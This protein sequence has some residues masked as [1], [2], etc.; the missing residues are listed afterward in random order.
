MK[1]AFAILFLLLTCSRSHSQAK[2]IDFMEIDRKAVFVKAESPAL[3]AEKLTS[4]YQTDIEKVRSIFRW[5]AEHIEYRVKFTSRKQIP[6]Q[7]N[8]SLDTGALT[9]LDE[10][11]A[12]SVF[13]N[14][15]AVCDGYARLFKA[16]CTYSGIQAV[17]ITGYA[18]T[19]EGRISQKFRSNH[20]WNA[21]MIDG[22]WRLIDVTWASGFLT[23]S[24]NEF[25]RRFDDRYFLTEPS[26]FIREHYPDDYRWTLMNDAPMMA[27]FRNSPFKQRGFVKYRI[28]SYSPAK[29]L[30][31]ASPGDTLAF[32]LR[33]ADPEK[34]RTISGDPF[35]DTSI[36]SAVNS[37]LLR[38]S[39]ITSA[40]TRYEFVVP[41]ASIEW[42]YLLYN[43]D[44]VLRYRVERKN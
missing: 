3:L 7:L 25:V 29:G 17:V 6:T 12:E 2:R 36:Y 34:D 40:Y 39:E 14:R 44:V 28:S 4:P 19:F 22:N 43:E 16:L 20:T 9:P 30:I 11:V 10:R 5:I 23:W 42:V 37:V 24:G 26:E 31:H 35:L 21:V 33:T 13:K 15:L 8:E 38:P 41:S 32:E 18:R 27:E 1:L